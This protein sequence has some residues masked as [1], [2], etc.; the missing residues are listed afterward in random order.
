MTNKLSEL[1]PLQQNTKT[2]SQRCDSAGR[3]VVS[4][5]SVRCKLKFRR[6]LLTMFRRR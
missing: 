2:F 3:L 5:L 1:N 6:R 4:T